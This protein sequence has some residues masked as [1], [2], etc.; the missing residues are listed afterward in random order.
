[1]GL[2]DCYWP[3][4]KVKGLQEGN[5]APRGGSDH[6]P[7]AAPNFGKARSGWLTGATQDRRVG[8]NSSTTN[9]Q[10]IEGEGVAQR[11]SQ[12]TAGN[13]SNCDNFQRQIC[14]D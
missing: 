12:N 8:E 4:G 1:M 5:T 11:Y 6:S 9:W 7:P 14:F 10:L 13:R 3:V 2:K